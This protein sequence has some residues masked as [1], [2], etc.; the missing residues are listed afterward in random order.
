MADRVDILL[1]SYNGELYIKEQIESI[2]SQTYENWRLL[3]SDDGSTDDTVRIISEYEKL[4]S[5][6]I[7]V[8]SKNLLG[9][10]AGNFFG[11][12]S[13]VK[14][15]YVMFCDQDDVWDHD[16]IENSLNRIKLLESSYGEKIPLLVFTDSRV[17]DQ[18]LRVISPSFVDTLSWNPETI[19]LAQAI[20][21]NVAQGS[22]M[23]FNRLLAEVAM[24]SNPLDIGTMHD[25]W[26]FLCVILFG[27]FSYLNNPTM[28][29]RQH[30]NN[31]IGAQHSLRSWV[32]RL[33]KNPNLIIGSHKRAAD[34][35]YKMVS[36][37]E[38]LYR[39]FLSDLS[40]EQK[41]ILET[42]INLPKASFAERLKFCKEY[43]LP[44][45]APIRKR[46][47]KVYGLLVI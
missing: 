9:N 34:N 8:E 46:A 47:Y 19:S 2:R 45:K 7:A 11:L 29:Y 32:L 23:M 17:V 20:S 3:I 27:H 5:R 42:I 18:N 12:L 38:L 26:I 30:A 44:S 21:D 33:V 16:K 6:I 4:D 14:S 39:I 15:A 31:S 10:A 43:Y 40:F 28:S 36:R 22:T 1:A 41:K 37:A 13:Y 25:W 24:Q 35:I